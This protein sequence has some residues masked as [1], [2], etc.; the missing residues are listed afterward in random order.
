MLIAGRNFKEVLGT[1]FE[2]ILQK[3]Q[4]N[5]PVHPPSARLENEQL[6]DQKVFT[7]PSSFINKWVVKHN[8]TFTTILDSVAPLLNSIQGDQVFE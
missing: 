7:P 1:Y 8:Y 4:Y 5:W 3:C 6:R 2:N